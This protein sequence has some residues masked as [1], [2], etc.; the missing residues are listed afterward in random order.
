LASAAVVGPLD[1]GHDRDPELFAGGP[2]LTIED[3]LLEQGEER[4]HGGVVATG[5]DLAHRSDQVVTAQGGHELPRPELAAPV[6]VV[7]AW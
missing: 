6:G 3:V 2:D 5:T 4:L 7:A 1:P